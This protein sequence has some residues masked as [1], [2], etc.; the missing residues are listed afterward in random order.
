MLLIQ[1]PDNIMGHK[2]ETDF[3]KWAR[4]GAMLSSPLTDAEK[5]ALI[6]LNI[7]GEIPEDQE[8]WMD[9]ILEFYRC[10]EQPHSELPIAKERLLD[11]KVDSPTIWADFRIYVGIDLD[12]E[13]MHWWE[14]MAL[15]KSLPPDALIQKKIE[16]RGIDL[17]EIKDTKLRED[18][19]LRK[20][21]VALD[22][23]DYDDF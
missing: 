6:F 4:F 10:G 23:Q 12:K 22:R 2:V 9:A 17:S 8:K 5:S 20:L 21:A 14:F 16:T 13:S 7:L 1:P 19:R 15:F 3:K 18:Y 11:W